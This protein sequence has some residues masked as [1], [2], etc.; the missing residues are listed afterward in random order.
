MIY[1]SKNEIKCEICEKVFNNNKDGKFTK[2]IITEHSLSLEEYLI[3]YFYNENDLKCEIC[4]NPVNI[5]RGIPHKRCKKCSHKKESHLVTM[6]CIICKTPFECSVS[7]SKKRKTCSKKCYKKYMSIVI[8]QAQ[9]NKTPEEKINIKRKM[10]QTKIKNNT[11]K[12]GKTWNKGLVGIYS[13]E[14]IDKIRQSTIKQMQENRYFK[15]STEIEMEKILNELE[16]KNKP[17]FV[18]ENK[19]FDFILLDYQI[20][21]EC[22]GD[23][24]H[25]N[26]SMPKFQKKLTDVQ[27]N[28]I[29]NDYY[30]NILAQ[31]NN[32]F[33]IRFWEEEIKNAKYIVITKILYA[34]EVVNN[35]KTISSQATKETK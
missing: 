19:V 25:T 4:G 7:A 17:S 29:K 32:F 26:S 33:L 6:E 35:Y 1:D 13:L 27:K 10:V 14:T 34:I 11:L 3:K 22:D 9:Y 30:K 8:K 12:T 2:H 18:I 23:F 20:L 21:I 24:W 16:I 15:S 31:K 28:N 5:R